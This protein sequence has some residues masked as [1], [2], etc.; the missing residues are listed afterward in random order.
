MR[1]GVV[2]VEAAAR[3]RVRKELRRWTPDVERWKVALT[4]R[5]RRRL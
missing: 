5:P 4:P 1:R 3:A 2:V